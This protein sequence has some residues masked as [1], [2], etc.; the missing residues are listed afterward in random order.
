MQAGDTTDY[1]G[2]WYEAS[3]VVP[4]PRGKLTADLDVDVCVVG[5]GLAGLTAALETCDAAGRWWCWRRGVA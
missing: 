5:A 1:G 3:M 4:L 2:S